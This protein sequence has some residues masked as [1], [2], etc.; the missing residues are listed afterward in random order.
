MGAFDALLP[1]DRF[2]PAYASAG[3]G[4]A[5]MFA[6]NCSSNGRDALFF[7]GHRH[8]SNTYTSHAECRAQYGLSGSAGVQPKQPRWYAVYHK[9]LHRAAL[10]PLFYGSPRLSAAMNQ[11]TIVVMPAYNAEKTLE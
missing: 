7:H 1:H 9:Q 4:Y 8:L 3:H 6:R 11:K 5:F 10:R 2:A